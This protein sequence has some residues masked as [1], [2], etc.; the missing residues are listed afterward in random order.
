MFADRTRSIS[1]QPP[2]HTPLMKPVQTRQ[3]LPHLP[4]AKILEADRTVAAVLGQLPLHVVDGGGGQG[5]D[6]GRVGT[7]VFGSVGKRFE[8]PFVGH[9]IY[10]VVS[11]GGGGAVA[12]FGGRYC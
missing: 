3:H 7:A 4:A 11:V 6:G 9:G 5:I 12:E 1:R 10:V 8:E 2:I